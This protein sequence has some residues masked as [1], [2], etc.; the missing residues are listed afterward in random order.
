[1]Y[2]ALSPGAMGIKTENLQ[3]AINVA[4][5]SG[6]EGVEVGILEVANLV[7]QLGAE[8]VRGLFDEAGIKPVHKMQIRMA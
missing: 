5:E 6:F 2:K 7:D 1:M 3:Q 4:R 8:H